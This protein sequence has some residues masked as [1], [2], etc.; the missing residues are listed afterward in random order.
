MS[1]CHHREVLLGVEEQTGDGG[2]DKRVE[3][4]SVVQLLEAEVLCILCVCVFLVHVYVSMHACVH[5]FIRVCVCV[6]VCVCACVC[7]CVCA[8]VRAC[9][10]ACACVCVGACV[11]LHVC[12]CS[13]NLCVCVLSGG[14]SEGPGEGSL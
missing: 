8:C 11:C 7:V 5:V 14:C 6:C 3:K 10:R 1:L 2:L 12:M 4:D 13:S 9:V